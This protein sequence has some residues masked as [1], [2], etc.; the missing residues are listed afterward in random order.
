[1]RQYTLEDIERETCLLPD[2]ITIT[3]LDGRGYYESDREQFIAHAIDRTVK[4][5]N[6]NP[7]FRR[8]L[9]NETG[10][11]WL[12]AFINHWLDAWTIGKER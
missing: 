6:C 3:V 10:R 8:K 5:F 2:V 4:A 12:Y 1:M 9:F 11:E 7:R